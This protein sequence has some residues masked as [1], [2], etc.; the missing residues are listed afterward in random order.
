MEDDL[1][2]S[3]ELYGKVQKV[4]DLLDSRFFSGNGK[5]KLPD[6]VFAINNKCQS[7]VTAY[8]SPEALYDKK[9]NKK[10][11]YLGINP[12]HLNRDL[13]DVL[14]TICH[15]MCHVYENTYI[16]I[17]RGG[18]HDKKW[19]ELMNDCGLEA[20]PLNKSRTAVAT[21][22]KDGGEF[23]EWVKIFREE[24]GEDYFNIVEYSQELAHEV[25]TALGL[26]DE[27]DDEP[28]ADNADKPVKKYNRNKTKYTCPD[29]GA[30]VWGKS[31]LHIECSDCGRLFEEENEEDDDE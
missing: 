26:G 30:H 14:A 23:K 1:K 15:E 13:K 22:I 20:V 21:R 31:G 16:H 11:Q 17:P 18:Y 27:D 10:L 7:S 2:V 19:E 24:Y 28:K 3:Q 8:V 12:R 6:V 29:C 9:N 5:Q 25:R 4:I